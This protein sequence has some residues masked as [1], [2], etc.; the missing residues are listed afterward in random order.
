MPKRRADAAMPRTASARR[1]QA[2]FTRGYGGFGRPRGGAQIPCSSF[3]GG[4]LL[5]F[6]M[7]LVEHRL[8]VGQLGAR[9]LDPVLDDRARA[10]FRLGLHA[11]VGRDDVGAGGLERV[12][13]DLVRVVPGLAVATRRVLV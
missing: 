5:Q 8:G 13:A 6:L 12:Q 4:D 9:L 10:L 3:A 2:G 1:S 11:R 7:E